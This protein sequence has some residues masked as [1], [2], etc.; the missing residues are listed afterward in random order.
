LPAS[1]T[2]SAVETLSPSGLESDLLI[3]HISLLKWA[4]DPSSMLF[5]SN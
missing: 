2:R 3:A 4:C 5:G 1:A